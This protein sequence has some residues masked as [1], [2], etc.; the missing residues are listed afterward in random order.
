MSRNHV[1]LAVAALA[2]LLSS[3][4]YFKDRG[5]DLVDPVRL[6]VGA[7]SVAGVRGRALGA[8]DTGLMM[9]VKPHMA[10]LGVKYGT[11]LYFNDSDERIDADQAEIIKTTSIIDMQYADGA[12]F[13]ARNS[14]AVL[15][16]VFTWTD[17]TPLGM[18]WEVP[19]EGNEFDD[20]HWLWSGE[21]FR[22]NRYAQVHAFDVEAEI[23][24]V[25][26]LD[27]G[28]SPGEI[29][30]LVLGLFTIDISRDDGRL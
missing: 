14:A 25:V 17:S 9:G 22:D 21:G 6:S 12:Y 27:A 7:G 16:A 24:L 26:Y 11:L 15:P 4:Q 5:T 28:L 30:D 13:S 2:P 8:V 1:A 20:R 23:G 10:A 29:L 19:D 18:G 3:C